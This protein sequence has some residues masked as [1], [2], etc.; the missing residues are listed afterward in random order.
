MPLLTDI[1]NFFSR[2]ARSSSSNVAT[3]G[4]QAESL[5]RAVNRNGR[6]SSSGQPA[7]GR[8]ATAEESSGGTAT[9]GV[10]VKPIERVKVSKASLAE[11]Q[12]SY[13]E[14]MSMVRKVSDHLDEQAK[15]TDRLVGL[16]DRLPDALQAVPEIQQ[17]NNRLLELFSQHLEHAR[18]RD[19]TLNSTLTRLS[20]GSASQN[21]VLSMLQKQIEAGNETSGRLAEHL[22]GFQSAIHQLA[23]SNTQ[24]AEVLRSMARN[25]E[26]RENTLVTMINKTQKWMIVGMSICGVASLAAVIVALSALLMAG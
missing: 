3:A 17:Q 1:R 22:G 2:T 25:S 5:G 21:E 15:R 14:V 20:E 13:H 11:V 12:Q 9:A 18:D 7:S 23:E 26:Q 6:E 8:R 4:T 19:E 10:E 24:S 16:M